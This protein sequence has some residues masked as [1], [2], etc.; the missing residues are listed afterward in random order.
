MESGA[1]VEMGSAGG[2]GGF[3][4]GRNGDLSGNG[5]LALSRLLAL[6]SGSFPRTW[7]HGNKYFA[8]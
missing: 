4:Q 8:L 7:I 3:V 2:T 1:G 6:L 5:N